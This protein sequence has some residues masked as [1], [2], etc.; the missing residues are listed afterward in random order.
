MKATRSYKYWNCGY[1]TQ[2]TFKNTFVRNDRFFA[3][4][5]ED[6]DIFAL[7]LSFSHLC[8]KKVVFTVNMAQR[9][10]RSSRAIHGARKC[11]LSS[12][13]YYLLCDHDPNWCLLKHCFQV[14]TTEY[15]FLWC[16][17]CKHTL[18]FHLALPNPCKH[19]LRFIYI[20]TKTR[21]FRVR[22]AGFRNLI[23]FFR[24]QMAKTNTKTPH[25]VLK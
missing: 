18:L 17:Q 20:T 12:P 9:S 25:F 22:L 19:P 23:F 5:D 6:P 3:V 24:D 16:H 21:R 10:I 7:L 15:E 1:L 8:A 4:E 11:C 13:T 14:S 2:L